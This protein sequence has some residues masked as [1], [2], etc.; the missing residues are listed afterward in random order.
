M[1]LLGVCDEIFAGDL[2]IFLRRATAGDPSSE[3]WFQYTNFCN[4]IRSAGISS[5][6]EDLDITNSVNMLSA[7]RAAKPQSDASHQEAHGFAPYLVFR[8]ALAQAVCAVRA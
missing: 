8:K 4:A 2:L 5:S 7:V 1:H 6:V 3:T